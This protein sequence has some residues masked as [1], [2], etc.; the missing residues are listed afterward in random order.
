MRCWLDTGGY[1][2][3]PASMPDIQGVAY[4]YPT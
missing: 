2:V 1:C 3:F 4:G